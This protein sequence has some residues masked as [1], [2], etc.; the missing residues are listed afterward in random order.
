VLTIGICYP[1]G[2]VMMYRWRTRHTIINGHPAP[3]HRQRVGA[4]R[5]LD[6]VVVPNHH[7]DR[8]LQLLGVP[9]ADEVD[10]RAPGVRPGVH[11]TVTPNRRPRATDR[12]KRPRQLCRLSVRWRRAGFVDLSHLGRGHGP[13][14]PTSWSPWHRRVATVRERSSTGWSV[15]VMAVIVQ[16]VTGSCASADGLAGSAKVEKHL[17]RCGGAGRDER[18]RDGPCAARATASAP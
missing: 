10:R 5:Q 3:V 2:V 16:P 11:A 8:D 17:P 14:H 15:R 13:C 1:W 6:Q 12:A 7:H 4:V 18:V 9:T